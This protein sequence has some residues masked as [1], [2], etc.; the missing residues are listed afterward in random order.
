LLEGF[1]E[2][3]KDAFGDSWD[4]LLPIDEYT[5]NHIEDSTVAVSGNL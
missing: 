4:D 2:A 3:M 1:V 5:L